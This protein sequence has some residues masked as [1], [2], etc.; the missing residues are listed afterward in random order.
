MINNKK[1]I[2]KT[3]TAIALSYDINEEAPKV[4]AKGKNHLA[5]K[6]IKS[7]TESKI[8][9]HKDE[10]LANNLSQ[11]EIG[12][13]IPPQLYDIVAEVLIFVDTMDKIKGKLNE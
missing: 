10:L 1:I 3:K 5:E 7:A 8:P 2:S 13:F 11:I 6:I 9:I 12:S 4:I